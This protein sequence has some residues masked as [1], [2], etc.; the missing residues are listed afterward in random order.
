MKTI[1]LGEIFKLLIHLL[2]LF[3]MVF[4][5]YNAVKF[6]YIQLLIVL[7]RSLVVQDESSVYSY[8]QK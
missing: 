4:P 3:M 5:A 6:T 8:F 2:K 1:R 7:L